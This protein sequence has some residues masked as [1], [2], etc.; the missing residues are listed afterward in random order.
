MSLFQPDLFAPASPA[1]TDP[2]APA[3]FRYRPELITPDEEAD[4]AAAFEDLAFRPY[5]FQGWL[6]RRETVAY[7]WRYAPDGRKVEAASPIPAFLL[8]VREKAGAFAGVDPGELQQAMVVRYP[9]GAPIGWHRDRPA[10]DKV[11]GVSLLTPAPLRL[12]A[13]SGEGW[14]RVTQRLER[15]SAY[16]LDGEARSRWEHS[17]PPL[18]AL[19]YSITFRTLAA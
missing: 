8:A 13:K 14:S 5:E 18:E 19:R 3:G 11:I 1:P 7:G 2:A 10:F 9:P 6:G 17:I 12:R 4:L 16:L 15:R